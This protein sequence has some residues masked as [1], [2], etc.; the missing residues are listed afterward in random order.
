MSL[1]ITKMLVPSSKYKI[2]C[3][4]KMSPQGITVHNTANDASAKSEISYMIKN[5]NQ[6]SY[7]YAVDDKGAYQGIPLDRNS[8]HAG[9]GGS[10]YGNRKTIGIEICYSK[11]GGSRFTKSENNAAK[12]IAQLMV[13]YG[14]KESDVGGKKINTHKSRSGKNCPH[15]TLPHMSAF[16]KK[17]K[18]EYKALT[19]KSTSTSKPKTTTKVSYYSKPNY[20][21]SSL[22]EALNKIKV[23][24][25]FAYRKKIAKAN[26]ISNYEGNASQN[27]KLL[28]LL[29]QG[30]LKKV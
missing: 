13:K 15:R 2:K 24:S 10:G 20:K 29:K 7:H 4:N 6:V 18:S 23:T 30:K 3:P 21:G 27:T 1:K 25:S 22:V 17:V 9:D 14:W 12:L 19:K 11:S 5:N 26:G 8:W 28:T 16:W